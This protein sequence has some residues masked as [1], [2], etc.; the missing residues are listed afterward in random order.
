MRN[1]LIILFLTVF[2]SCTSCN[3]DSPKNDSNLHDNDGF[4]EQDKDFAYDADSTDS[5]AEK[6]NETDDD[7]ADS[8]AD[9]QEAEE[10]P[11]FK[12]ANFPYYREDGSIHFCRK[13]D[14][15]A[16]SDDPDCVRNLWSEINQKYSK[17]FPSRDC[18]GYPCDVKTLKAGRKE[19]I[20][21]P[22]TDCD[23]R[24]PPVVDAIWSA[25]SQNFRHSSIWNEKVGMDMRT[26][27]SGSDQYYK[28]P[29]DH[30]IFSYNVEKDEYT[31]IMP[32]VMDASAYRSG[33]HLGTVMDFNKIHDDTTLGESM[34]KQ[35]LV[36]YDEVKG[37][38][39]IYND[40]IRY[41]PESA[42]KMSDEW[43]YF[44]HQKT[45]DDPYQILYAKIGEWKWHSLGWGIL[46][47]AS[48]GGKYLGIT[49]N[50]GNGYVCNLEKLPEGLSKCEKVNGENQYVYS[51]IFDKEQN[52]RFATS[53]FADELYN[54]VIGTIE[55]SGI[56]YAVNPVQQTESGTYVTI[57]DSF[58][59]DKV[60]YGELFSVSAETEDSKLCYYSIIKKEK[61]CQKKIGTKYNQIYG[62]FEGKYLIW[63]SLYLRDME[64]YCKLEPEACPFDEYMPEV[65]VLKKR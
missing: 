25:G 14:L 6:D 62:D 5:I 58:S 63:Q 16:K 50:K 49:D 9:Y 34:D 26:D 15:P 37:Y 40:T 43:V 29:T 31:V 59:G 18:N 52:N 35:Y 36:M 47:E 42:M 61:Y 17:D 20:S 51:V 54:I 48:L 8:D 19:D 44:I 2:W 38:K 21:T 33:K 22:I 32:T 60:L 11:Q 46:Y 39:V 64:C 7:Q 23:R 65:P 24:V 45:D 53:Y 4:V 56:K 12:Y 30:R 57:V 41:L 55:E 13:C 28:Y 27:F 10:C 3:S 1:I